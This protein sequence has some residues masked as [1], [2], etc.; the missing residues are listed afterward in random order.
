MRKAHDTDIKNKEAE[1]ATLKGKLKV[2]EQSSGAGAKKISDLKQEYE[3]TVKS[4]YIILHLQVSILRETKEK[5]EKNTK[6]SMENINHFSEL[7]HSLAVEKAEYEELTGKYE[8]LEEE[9]VVTKARL[10]VEKEQAQG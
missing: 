8:I 9:H 4:E 2:L 5:E 1:L 10:T 3:E 6:R 7:E